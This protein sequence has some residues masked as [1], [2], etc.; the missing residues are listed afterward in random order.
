MDA[1][2]RRDL[3]VEPLTNFFVGRVKKDLRQGQTYVGAI[4]TAVNRG[5]ET[6]LLRSALPSA[7]YTVGMDF[8]HEF[9][10]RAWSFTGWLA[11]SHV[12]GDS[13]A[14]ALVQRRPFHYFQRPDADHLELRTDRTSMSGLAGELRVRRQAG[15]HWRGTLGVGTISPTF[16]LFDIGTQRRGDRVDL[17]GSVTYLRQTPGRFWRYWEVSA[18][19]RREHNYDREHIFSQGLLAG[20]FQHL[21]YWTVNLNVAHVPRALDD[22]LTRGGPL[23]RRPAT[24][25]IATGRTSRLSGATT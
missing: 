24:R 17:D 11:A 12:R 21:N 23:A 3:L 7:G 8:R 20:F 14:L 19:A 2:G 22:R 25:W 16:D 6:D 13:A 5:L 10:R 9:D 1:S 18:I 15:A 4:A